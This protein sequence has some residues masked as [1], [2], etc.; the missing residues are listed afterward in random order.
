MEDYKVIF[1][2]DE[3][4]KW[5]HLLTNVS[6][7]LSGMEGEKLYVEVLANSEAVKYYDSTLDLNANINAMESLNKRNVKFAACN[8]ALKAYHIKNDNLYNFID[9][10][11]AGVV[12]LVKKQNEGYAYIK[13]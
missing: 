1:H 4:N 8:N 13:P 10:V 9:V 11:P 2:I 12:E 6:N 7:L 3:I 5:K